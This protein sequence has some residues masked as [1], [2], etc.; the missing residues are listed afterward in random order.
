MA[1]ICV[2]VE[3]FSMNQDIYIADNGEVK[4]I[5]TVPMDRVGEMVFSLAGTHNIDEVEINGNTEYIQQIGY[6]ILDGME[7]FYSNKNVRVKL[8][9]KVF[10]K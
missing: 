1:K 7:K 4:H 10:N 3:M 9:G 8:N 6:D 5:A 2:K